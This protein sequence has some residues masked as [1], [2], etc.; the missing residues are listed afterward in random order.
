MARS[1]NMTMTMISLQARHPKQVI[2]EDYKLHFL[3]LQTVEFPHTSGAAVQGSSVDSSSSISL[4]SSASSRHSQPTP[5]RTAEFLLDE[6]E[7]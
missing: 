5:S 7:C 2:T 1:L 6:S 3:L 4:H